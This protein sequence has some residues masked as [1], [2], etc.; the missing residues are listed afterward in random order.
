M[1]GDIGGTWTHALQWSALGALT[2]N[3]TAYYQLTLDINE[4][5]N[6]PARFISLDQMKIYSAASGDLTSISQLGTAL[7]DLNLQ[8]AVIPPAAGAAPYVWG[9]GN[10]SAVLF[11]YTLAGSGHGEADI[12]VF[13][14]QSIF[15]GKVNPNDHFYLYSTFGAVGSQAFTN[16]P[17]VGNDYQ[18][19]DGYEEWRALQG[20]VTVP[21]PGILLLLGAGL[22]GL[23]IPARRRVK[24]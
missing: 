24:K 16:S 13:I 8:T 19:E 5:A 21:E 20:G 2:L 9:S 14:P 11:D 6:G 18:A 4:P 15:A 7:W 22:L 1:Y 23:G 12:E 3:G 10:V 17:P